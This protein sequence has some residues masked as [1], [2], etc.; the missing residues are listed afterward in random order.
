MILGVAFDLDG[1]LID[2]A[3]ALSVALSKAIGEFGYRAEPD[4]I[5]K[6][7]GLSFYDIVSKFIKNPD[8]VLL[9]KIKETRKKYIIESISSFRIFPDALY[10]L[11]A[12][13]ELGVKSA[14]ATSLGKDLIDFVIL[15]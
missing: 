8:R 2:N 6:Y 5:R 4:E 15:L 14:V 12:L 3:D 13:K 1:T 9:E 11:K 10:A 7:L